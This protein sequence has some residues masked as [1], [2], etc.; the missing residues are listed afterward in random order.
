MDADED[1][2]DEIPVPASLRQIYSAGRSAPKNEIL[3]AFG[4]DLNLVIVDDVMDRGRWHTLA[5]LSPLFLAVGAATENGRLHSDEPGAEIVAVVDWVSTHTV[6][7]V[8]EAQ[9]WDHETVSEGPLT[10][11]CVHEAVKLTLDRIMARKVNRL[12][13]RW[14]DA[15]QM[16][17]HGVYVSS[18]G[19]R[20]PGQL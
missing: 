7:T 18:G 9:G 2:Y 17:R 13:G 14:V 5:Y 16:R 6:L 10:V 19:R 8:L 11:R 4:R 12:L 1:D 20:R 15:G 3:A